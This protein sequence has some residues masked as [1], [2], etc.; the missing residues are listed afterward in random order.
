MQTERDDLSNAI[1]D[2]PV[3]LGPSER[4]ECMRVLLTTQPAYGHF[5]PMLPLAVAL[6]SAGHDVAFA[7]SAIFCPV[8]HQHGFP[9]FPVGLD[10]TESDWNTLPADE[11]PPPEASTEEFFAA[12]FVRLTGSHM[13]PDLL[14]LARHW[15]PDLIVRETT[16]FSGALVAETLGLPHAAVQVAAPSAYS[17]ELLRQA[18]VPYNALRRQIGLAHD[19]DLRTLRTETVLAFAPPGLNDPKV[20]LV[21]SNVV[22][23]R[24]DPTAELPAGPAPAWIQALG[25][26]GRRVVYATL[27][28][29]VNQVPV[30]FFRSVLDGLRDEEVDIV[31]TVGP[32]GDPDA[33]GPLPPNTR[34]ERYVPQAL[35][36]GR[37]DVV[38]FHGGFGTLLGAL[39]NGV[40]VVVVPFGADQPENARSCE[41]RGFGRV[42]PPESLSLEAVRGAVLGVLNDPAYRL[43]ATSVRDE[44]RALPGPLEAVSLLEGLVAHL[45]ISL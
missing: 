36:L 5:F 27:G 9:A 12:V 34:V 32:N 38:V 41:A 29:V 25:R 35:L 11:F 26:G 21:S 33:F 17:P 45:N 20:P 30:P 42:L 4:R 2:W 3:G 18:A 7:T 15:C 16:E 44:M 39:Q 10:W 24:P 22:W 23:L 40:P 31:V 8:V 37:C 13:L 19:P 6:R 14:A 1:R 28:T 43:A